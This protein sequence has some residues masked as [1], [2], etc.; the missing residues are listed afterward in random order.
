[1][2]QSI[3]ASS[4]SRSVNASPTAAKKNPRAAK[5]L[6]GKQKSANVAMQRHRSKVMFSRW[7]RAAVL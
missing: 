5:A 2:R 4:F 1:M 3:G 6:R 7:L